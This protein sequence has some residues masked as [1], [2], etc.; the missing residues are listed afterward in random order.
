M[1]HHSK[2]YETL[3]T[4]SEIDL[5]FRPASYWEPVGSKGRGR[6]STPKKD[7]DDDIFSFMHGWDLP[8]LRKGEVEIARLIYTMTANQEVT[9][10]RARMKGGKIHYRIASELESESGVHCGRSTSDEPL[11]LREL[12]D[13]IEDSSDEDTNRNGLYFGDLQHRL[14]FSDCTEGIDELEGFIR[15]ESA[16]YPTIGQWYDE[17]CAEWC[18]R[19][20]ADREDEEESDGYDEEEEEDEEDEED[21]DES[22][23]SDA[24]D[25]DS[26]SQ[27][28]RA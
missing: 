25:D 22:A 28:V 10:I 24:P 13:L 14:C 19:E 21:Q 18:D 4:T 12:I 5:D 6:R 17:A 8:A 11:T 2:P 1:S 9:S 16:F 23:E 26:D 27:R 3:N 20:R 15:V 7:D